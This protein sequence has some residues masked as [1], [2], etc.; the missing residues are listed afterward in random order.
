MIMNENRK[1][2]IELKRTHEGIIFYIFEY[3]TR[4]NIFFL[5]LRIKKK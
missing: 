3:L 1:K 4:L 5:F 2:R